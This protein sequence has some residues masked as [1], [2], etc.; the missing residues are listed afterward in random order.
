MLMMLSPKDSEVDPTNA[1]LQKGVDSCKAAMNAPPHAN[2]P[3]LS[4]ELM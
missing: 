4:V 2:S 1:Q 3:I